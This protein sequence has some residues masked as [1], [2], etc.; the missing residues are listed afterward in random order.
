MIAKAVLRIVSKDILDILGDAQL[1]AGQVSGCETG[2]HAMSGIQAGNQ[3]QA[4]LLVDASNAFNSLDREVAM[5]NILSLCPS[6][7]KMVINTYRNDSPLFIDGESILSREGTT[8][9]DPLA[10]H[11]YAIATIPLIRKLPTTVE[12]VWYADD[13]SAGGRVDGL[14]TWWDKIQEIGPQYGYHPC[15][16]K[17]WLIVKEDYLSLVEQAFSGSGVNITTEGKS[18][19]G[20]PIG[21]NSFKKSFLTKK[22]NQWVKEVELLSKIT[23][24]QPQSAYCALTNGLMSSWNYLMRFSPNLCDFL[25]PLEDTIQTLACHHRPKE[26]Q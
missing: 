18:H 19:L 6:L 9:G 8:Q 23:L 21:S 26:L 12:H 3:T 17:S 13:A 11:I 20:A 5:R 10:M 2:V 22:I 25:Q 14:R 7:A 4:I 15:A 24:S 16:E 1:C